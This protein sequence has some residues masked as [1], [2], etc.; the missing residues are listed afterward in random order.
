MAY[1]Y[2][3]N[4]KIFPGIV[5]NV[6]NEWEKLLYLGERK[7]YQAKHMFSFEREDFDDFAYLHSGT[8]GV[9][10]IKENASLHMEMLYEKGTLLNETAPILGQVR[11][12]L[13][14][15]CK[16]DV[17]LYQFKSSLLHNPRFIQNYPYLIYSLLVGQVVKSSSQE[18]L[19]NGLVGR[20]ALQKVCWYLSLL[21]EKNQCRTEFA[22]GLSQADLTQLLNI[23][24]SSMA[25]CINYLKQQG[26]IEQFSKRSLKIRSIEK[27]KQVADAMPE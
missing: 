17:V 24:K 9:V 13:H 6:N 22:P 14:F 3:E 2:S 8:I 18:M 26:I 21:H 19:R 4:I 15:L 20:T 1:F 10:N 11:S 16:T 12:P 5:E 23:H 25:R 7:S 27:L